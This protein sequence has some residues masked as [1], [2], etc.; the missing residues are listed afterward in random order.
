ML[1]SKGTSMTSTD[2]CKKSQNPSVPKIYSVGFNHDAE[3]LPKKEFKTAN[4]SGDILHKRNKQSDWQS[5][6]LGQNARPRL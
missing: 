6:F 1:G 2:N 5:E 3:L 4:H